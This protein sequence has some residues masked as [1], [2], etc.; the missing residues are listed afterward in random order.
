MAASPLPGE[1]KCTRQKWVGSKK[2]LA[3]SNKI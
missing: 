2:T 1:G 3:I